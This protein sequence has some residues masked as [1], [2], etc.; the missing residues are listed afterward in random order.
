MFV[1]VSTNTH[2]YHTIPYHTIPYHTIQMSGGTWPT[3]NKELIAKYQGA[4][5]T[6]INSIDFNKLT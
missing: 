6:F 4:F 2:T 3:S 5:T 1:F